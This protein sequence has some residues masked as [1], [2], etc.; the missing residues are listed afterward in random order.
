M[1]KKLPWPIRGLLIL[2]FYLLIQ[3]PPLIVALI[4]RFI[5]SSSGAIISAILYVL[6]FALII[7]WAY[8]LFQ[9]YQRWPS[10]PQTGRQTA[11]W[12]FGGWFVIILGENLLSRLNQVLYHQSDTANNEALRQLMAGGRESML[13]MLLA[14][15]VLSPIA[16]ELIFR[17][18]LMN[19]FFKDESFWPP[20]LLSGLCFTLAHSSTT[21]I[22]YL[23]YFYMGVVF[24]YV[25]RRTGNLKNTIFL[26]S[27]NNLLA[28]L[29]LIASI[30]GH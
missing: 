30:L 29:G 5:H 11:G 17:G 7:F 6:I 22:S 24:A 27:F 15:I 14:A 13:L 23:I 18:L 4:P 2:L 16:E 3:I 8:L 21:P 10:Q 26:H 12:V 1:T 19:F 20:I 9:R 28:S 25:Y